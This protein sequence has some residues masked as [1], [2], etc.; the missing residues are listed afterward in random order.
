MSLMLEKKE[1]SKAGLIEWKPSPWTPEIMETMKRMLGEGKS[2]PEI[3]AKLGPAFTRS[4]VLGRMN[5]LGLKSGWRPV[6][7]APTAAPPP[8][9]LRVQKKLGSNHTQQLIR[10][11]QPKAEPVIVQVPV[12]IPEPVPMML[13][14]IELTDRTCKFAINETK[15]FLFC[16]HPVVPGKPWC[17]H[18][19][20]RCIDVAGWR[21]KT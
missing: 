19:A 12:N 6:K 3:A 7:T 2:S 8:P 18:H 1:A 21:K 10:I 14:L 9:S 13:S 5:R 17:P 16:G 20:I 15:P 4:A 11:T